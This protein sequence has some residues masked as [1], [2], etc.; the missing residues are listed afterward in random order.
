MSFRNFVK[1]S[2]RLVKQQND[3]RLSIICD[4]VK[5]RNI[6]HVYL[7]AYTLVVIE[8]DIL[9]KTFGR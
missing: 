2:F 4:S 1:Q 9:R 3:V 7:P 8:L 5:A 6:F